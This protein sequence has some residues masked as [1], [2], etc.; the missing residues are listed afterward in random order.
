MSRLDIFG[1]FAQ[2]PYRRDSENTS[3][4]ISKLKT[5]RWTWDDHIIVV[6]RLVH[7]R[8]VEFQGSGLLS[9][10]GYHLG[11]CQSPREQIH[12]ISGT[13]L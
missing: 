3:T 6:K 1:N 11:F 5:E 10:T 9:K 8:V 7:L 2:E 13:F 4:W 12:Q